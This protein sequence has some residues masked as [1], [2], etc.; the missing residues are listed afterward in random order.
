LTINHAKTIILR[1]KIK[2]LGPVE[3]LRFL[4][5]LFS[6]LIPAGREHWGGTNNIFIGLLLHNTFAAINIFAMS[7]R[8]QL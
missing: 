4:I 8:R 2:E 5:Y 1:F 3:F 7:L 6:T